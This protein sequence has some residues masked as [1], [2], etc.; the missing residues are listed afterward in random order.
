MSCIY[1]SYQFATPWTP[2]HLNKGT[3]LLSKGQKKRETKGSKHPTTQKQTLEGHWR[4]NLPPKEPFFLITKEKTCIHQFGLAKHAPQIRNVEDRKGTWIARRKFEHSWKIKTATHWC[5][6]WL[7]IYYAKWGCEEQTRSCFSTHPE[8]RHIRPSSEITITETSSWYF[9]RSP[10]GISNNSW[11]SIPACV[12][13]HPK[14]ERLSCQRKFSNKH[15]FFSFCNQ[16]FKF[17]KYFHNFTN[18]KS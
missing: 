5:L 6:P 2:P 14:K 3:A 8:D 10:W 13:Q 17:R 15:I 16:Q 12:I 7:I 11:K 9:R 4:W 1:A 18:V